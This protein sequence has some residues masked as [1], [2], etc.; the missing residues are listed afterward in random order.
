MT[1][2]R[3]YLYFKKICDDFEIHSI[4]NDEILEIESVYC[5]IK[6][7]ETGT[8]LEKKNSQHF[9]KIIVLL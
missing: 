7:I 9:A 8:P 2:L 3:I 5:S 1:F 4:S 6:T